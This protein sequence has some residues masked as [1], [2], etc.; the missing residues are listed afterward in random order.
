MFFVYLKTKVLLIN[1]YMFFKHI[2]KYCN[3]KEKKCNK[4]SNPLLNDD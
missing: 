3:K 4:I 2:V 1:M